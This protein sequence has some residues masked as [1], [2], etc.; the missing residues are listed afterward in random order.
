MILYVKLLVVIS[1]CKE[2]ES[3]NKLPN[4]FTYS[5]DCCIFYHYRVFAYNEVVTKPFIL[6]FED[7]FCR[8]FFY[9]CS[10]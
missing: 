8:Y 10:V 2:I 3:A 6:W 1:L 9:N 4:E 5:V 7:Y